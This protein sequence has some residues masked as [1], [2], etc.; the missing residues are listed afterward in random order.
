MRSVINRKSITLSLL[1]A[2]PLVPHATHAY[3]D[4]AAGTLAAGYSHAAALKSNGSVWSWG[5][6]TLGNGTINSS[7][8]PVQAT[9]LTG[10]V[11]I[12]SGVSYSIALK[13]DGTLRV[14]GS[15]SY[16]QLGDGTTT[17]RTTPVTGLWANSIAIATSDTDG[18]TLAVK[19]DRTVWS[20]G[21]NNWGTLGDGT[22]VNRA[23]PVQVTGLTNVLTVAVG[24][25][26]ALAVKLDGTVWTW[27]TEM[28][29]EFGDGGASNSVQLTPIQVPGLTNV[30]AVSAGYLS[31]YALKSDGSVWAWGMNAHGQLG[32]GS[33]Y[34]SSSVPMQIVGLAGI[35]A[36]AAGWYHAT[37]LKSDGTVSAWGDNTYGGLGDGTVTRRYTPV[38]VSSLSNVVAISNGYQFSMAK[39]SNGTVKAWGYNGYGQLG[40]GTT[41]NRLTPVSVVGL[42]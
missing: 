4:T 32:L 18:I 37:A 23:T 41:T 9:G 19:S 22:M 12:N 36:I 34:S 7:T 39:T 2:L 42:P 11:A 10:V 21:N 27:G 8:T 20:A 26:H 38:Q 30:V 5:S 15:N 33:A 3:P 28:S 25:Y 29:G 14:W 6:N 35:T 17:L 13:S 24:S 16:G 31:S 1:L 40:D